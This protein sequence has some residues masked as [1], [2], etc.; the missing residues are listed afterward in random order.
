M[1]Q[2]TLKTLI[3]FLTIISS[4]SCVAMNIGENI[5]FVSTNRTDVFNFLTSQTNE[6][7]TPTGLEKNNRGNVD[8]ILSDA[9]CTLDYIKTNNNDLDSIPKFYVYIRDTNS[10]SPFYVQLKLRTFII[11]DPST[12]RMKGMGSEIGGGHFE[13]M[14]TGSTKGKKLT[15]EEEVANNKILFAECLYES[16]T[17][18]EPRHLPLSK[19][20]IINEKITIPVAASTTRGRGG[21][22]PAGRTM[23]KTIERLNWGGISKP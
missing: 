9:P 1:E 2:K 23:V 12:Y 18:S 8:L 4:Y 16:L 7:D 10:T 22:G 20:T 19:P 11:V 21:R 5:L 17:K 6:Y 14:R 15:P 13:T 3:L